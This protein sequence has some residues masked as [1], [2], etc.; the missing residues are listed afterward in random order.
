M[1]KSSIY[2]LTINKFMTLNVL[3]FDI[4]NSD[5]T[6]FMNKFELSSESHIIQEKYI[7]KRKEICVC[8]KIIYQ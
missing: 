1:Y 6:A 3:S 2:K 5:R 4:C 7:D 8:E